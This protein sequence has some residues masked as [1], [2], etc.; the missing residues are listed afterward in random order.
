MI[1]SSHEKSRNTIGSLLNTQRS[2]ATPAQ[3]QQWRSCWILSV[4]PEHPYSGE[5]SPLEMDKLDQKADKLITYSPQNSICWKSK[6]RSSLRSGD[7]KAAGIIFSISNSRLFR[8]SWVRTHRNKR[9]KNCS[10]AERKNGLNILL[11][12]AFA[13]ELQ[14][15]KREP[16]GS[17]ICTAQLSGSS[18]GDPT[19]ELDQPINREDLARPA[20][21]C[22]HDHHS[23]WKK[24]KSDTEHPQ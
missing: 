5:A 9:L 11:A 23:A 21:F 18:H 7:L 1:K 2:P 24:S 4:A 12:D 22:G 16:S 17:G 10:K 3:Y 14:K 6:I 13:R 15:C 19:G 8:K 20:R